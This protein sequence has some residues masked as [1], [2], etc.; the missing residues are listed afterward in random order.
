MVAVMEEITAEAVEAVDAMD[1]I[2]GTITAIMTV[3][4]IIDEMTMGGMIVVMMVMD[5]PSML[6]LPVS[7]IEDLNVDPTMPR[8]GPL[9]RET[10][11]GHRPREQPAA[12]HRE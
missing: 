9:V 2:G 7:R 12:T 11:A 5:A 1:M 6:L 3:E 8:K 4:T 10:R